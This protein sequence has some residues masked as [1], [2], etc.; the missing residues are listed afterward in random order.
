VAGAAIP[1]GAVTFS[2][3][4]VAQPPVPLA[5]AFGQGQAG[6]TMTALPPGRHTVTALYDP[7]GDFAGSASGA[8]TQVVSATLP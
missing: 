8:L 6:F 1:T 4:G 3:D 7:R 5:A 2:I